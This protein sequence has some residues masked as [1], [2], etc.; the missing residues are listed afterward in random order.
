MAISSFLG[1]IYFIE[2]APKHWVSLKD[3]IRINMVIDFF[4]TIEFH[5]P[6]IQNYIQSG[7]GLAVI[8]RWGRRG[9]R[10]PSGW[11][12]SYQWWSWNVGTGGTFGDCIPESRGKRRRQHT[13][14]DCGSRVPLWKRN[15]SQKN[16][17][18]SQPRQFL[19]L[20][21]SLSRARLIAH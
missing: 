13:L 8:N 19:Q 2:G 15:Q 16:E 4:K 17:P 7:E 1:T 11:S 12:L 20:D 18:T 10:M 3:I 9:L 21:E 6:F 14:Q 5:L